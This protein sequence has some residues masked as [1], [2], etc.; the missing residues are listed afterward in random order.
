M[1]RPSTMCHWVRDVRSDAAAGNC[2][3]F[4]LGGNMFATTSITMPPW[5]C[6]FLAIENYF[7]SDEMKGALLP[8][9]L[10]M[11]GSNKGRSISN[12]ETV[13]ARE[14]FAFVASAVQL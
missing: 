7:L 11:A 8:R 1:A 9:P 10:V 6:C 14:Q 12:A 5:P 3:W 13:G 4:E 2:R